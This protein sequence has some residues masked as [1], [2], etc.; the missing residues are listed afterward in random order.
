MI[1]QVTHSNLFDMVERYARARGGETNEQTDSEAQFVAAG[2]YQ[3]VL[4][5]TTNLP[6]GPVWVGMQNASSRATDHGK[7]FESVTSAVH[8]MLLMTDWRR[9]SIYYTDDARE[10]LRWMADRIDEHYAADLPT[11]LIPV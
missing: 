8:K 9:V 1:E 2:P 7:G 10:R 11:L 6:C 4:V 3:G 5:L